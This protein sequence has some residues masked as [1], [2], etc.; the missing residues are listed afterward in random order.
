MNPISMQPGKLYKVDGLGRTC[1]RLGNTKHLV[2]RPL[3][4][5]M[6]MTV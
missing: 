2:V 1:M 3:M 5:L 4:K 6:A